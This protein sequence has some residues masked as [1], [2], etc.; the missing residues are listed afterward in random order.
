M[1]E[2]KSNFDFQLMSLSYKLRDLF[3]PRMNI[4]KEIGIKPG[5]QVLDYGCGPGSY[6]PPLA[7]LLGESGKIYA[8]DIHPLAVQKVRNITAKKKLTKV[9]TI[10]SECKTGLPADT[11]DV[12]LLFDILHDLEDPLSVLAELH[13]VLKPEGILSVHDHHLKEKELIARLSDSGLFQLSMKGKRVY[14]FTKIV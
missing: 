2:L 3:K 10:Q 7:E 4:L 13:T 5:F 1:A 12:A 6:I 11:I 9:E 8:L 14:N